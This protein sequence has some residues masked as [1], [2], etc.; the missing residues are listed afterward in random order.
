[1]STQLKEE[2]R[3]ELMAKL[4]E[5]D[6]YGVW[7]DENSKYEEYPPLTLREARAKWAELSDPKN[8]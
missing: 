6:R 8:R 1:M 4:Q 3:Q 5:M 2:E 7:T